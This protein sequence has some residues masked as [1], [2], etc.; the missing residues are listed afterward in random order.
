MIH[1]FR[2]LA[3]AGAPEFTLTLLECVPGGKAMVFGFVHSD[4]GGGG[5]V[6]IKSVQELAANDFLDEVRE[7]KDESPLLAMT[8]QEVI[9]VL[10]RVRSRQARPPPSRE[11]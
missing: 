11:S 7:E 8:A 2:G 10:L 4:A 6:R 5:D 1:H 9:E 3:L